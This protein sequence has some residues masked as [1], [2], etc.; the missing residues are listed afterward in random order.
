[1][2]QVNLHFAKTHLSRLIQQAM[3]GEEVI[4]AR[5]GT[6]L[7]RLVPVDGPPPARTLGLDAGQ[8]VIAD[9]FDA[10][11]SDLEAALHGEDDPYGDDKPVPS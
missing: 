6:P 10:P 8:L 2:S 7:V 9:D 1:M 4:L 11:L 5:A 3:S